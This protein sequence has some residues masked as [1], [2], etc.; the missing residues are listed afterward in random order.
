MKLTPEFKK[1]MEDR[2]DYLR[3]T[4]RTEVAQKIKEA[5]AFG[6]ISENAEYDAAKEEQAMIEGEI[7]RLENALKSAEIIEDDV[8]KDV[9]DVGCTVKVYDE[10][11][12]EEDTY[13]IL[14]SLQAD[15]MNNIISNESPMGK[16]LMGAKVGQIVKF[17]APSGDMVSLKIL[18]IK[19]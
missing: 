17:K 5:R 8:N 10:E 12:Q 9:V 1:Q 6:D 2:L 13:Q 3:V 14:G 19:Y 15:P 7:V 11:F 16:A 18:E 4:A